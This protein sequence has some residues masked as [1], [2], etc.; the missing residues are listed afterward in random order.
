VVGSDQ[1]KKR[2]SVLI[3]I[4]NI[5]LFDQKPFGSK[6]SV[7]AT[8]TGIFTVLGVVVK[9]GFWKKRKAFFANGRDVSGVKKCE[10][11]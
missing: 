4:L 6:M 7:I 3:Q 1:A 8:G 10:K 5:D 2:F 9:K 11:K